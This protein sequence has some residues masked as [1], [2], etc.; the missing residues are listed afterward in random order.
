M[1]FYQLFLISYYES[2]FY[3][4]FLQI[5]KAF[6]IMFTLPTFHSINYINNIV[7]NF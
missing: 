3:V 4:I 1:N 2:K 5:Q 6:I 7:L